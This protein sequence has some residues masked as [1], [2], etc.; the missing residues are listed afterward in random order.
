MR[1]LHRV[2]GRIPGIRRLL[3]GDPFNGS[4][5]YW[6]GRYALGGTSGRGSYGELAAY[7]ADFLNGFVREHAVR[8]VLEFGCGDGN[9]LSLAEYPEYVG[10]DVSKSAILR[11]RDRFRGD[12]TK[13]FFLYDGEAFVDRRPHFRADLTLSLDVLFHL[14]EEA[15]WELHLR[16]LFGAAERFVIAYSSDSDETSREAHIVH[17][18][19]TRWVIS[20]LDSWRLVQTIPNPH[21]MSLDYRSGTFADFHVFTRAQTSK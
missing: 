21:P 9:Q 2:I 20:N 10:L 5:E 17:R 1:L 7:K 12:A 14:T 15:V 18:P 6:E 13:S 16:H 19:F 8:S 3:R 11:C 4:R